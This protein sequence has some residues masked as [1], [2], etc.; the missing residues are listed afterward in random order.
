M[1]ASDPAHASAPPLTFWRRHR[2]KLL[3]S[4]VVGVAFAAVLRLGALPLVPSRA[5]LARVNWWAVAGYV[6]IWQLVHLL[7]AGRWY[8]LLAPLHRVPL[9]RVLAVASVGFAAIMFL[10]F[11]TGEVVRPVMIRER[12]QLS[13]WA[14]TG[15]VGAERIVDGL[16]L[17]V[18]LFAALQLSTP[19]EPL[20]DHIGRL[21]VPAS[22]VPGAAYTALAVFFGAFTT[23]GVFYWRRDWARRTTRRV[24]GA[25]SP[26]LG[27]WLAAR[28]EEVASGLSFLPQARFTVPF[29]VATLAYWGL[30]ALG[31]WLLAWGC[32]FHDISYAQACAVMGV[33]ALGIL[34]PNAPGFFGSFQIAVYAGFAMFFPPEQVIGPGSAYVFCLYVVQVVTTV[35][36]GLIGLAVEQV[37]PREALELTRVSGAV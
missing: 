29:L 9:Q 15:S 34:V 30:N 37:R 11:R 23:M 3:A 25:V 35:C 19:L 8:W 17:S 24:V 32:G 21:P 2:V 6:V 27:D 5:D 14:A 4:L 31:A 12:G 13:A 26:R 36:A 1:I 10:P 20:P 7:R 28:I 33:L 22:V 18:I 16:L